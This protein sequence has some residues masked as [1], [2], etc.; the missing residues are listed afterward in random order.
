MTELLIGCGARKSKLLNLTGKPNWTNRV[1]LDINP[2]HSPDILHDLN[3]IPWPM[4]ENTCDEIH[5][6]EVIEHLGQQGDWKS[7][8]SMWSEIWRIMKGGAIF[9]GT[10]P[11]WKS[12]WAWGEPGHTRVISLETLSFLDQTEYTK[13][14]GVTPMT[15]YRFIYKEDFEIVLAQECDDTFA[16]ALKCIKPS[17]IEYANQKSVA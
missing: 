3:D 6:Y 7:Y 9:F 8:F 4:G 15:D 1:T 12:K 11:L 17:R 16:F 2:D 14:I 5:A 10:C 13:Q